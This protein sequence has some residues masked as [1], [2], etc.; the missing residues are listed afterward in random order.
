MILE[1]LAKNLRHKLIIVQSDDQNAPLPE[2]LLDMMIPV[3]IGIQLSIELKDHLKSSH[4][5][6]IAQEAITN[7]M[8]TSRIDLP[9]IGPGIVIC[10]PGILL[11]ESLKINFRGFL[12]NHSQNQVLVLIWPGEIYDDT[13]FFLRQ[14]TGIPV[15][16]KDLTYLIVDLDKE[17]L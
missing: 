14:N 5:S 13:L 16:L 11:E 17:I 4:I 12:E 1:Y 15:S 7:I 6:G 10:N 2:P 3:D 8:R 9:E